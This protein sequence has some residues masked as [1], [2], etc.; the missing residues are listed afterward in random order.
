MKAIVANSAY[1]T[2]LLVVTIQIITL[3]MMHGK[4]LP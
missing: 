1:T 4:S 2:G 3:S